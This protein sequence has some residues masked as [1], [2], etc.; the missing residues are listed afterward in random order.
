MST[1]I[2]VNLPVKDLDRT[3]AFFT[4]LG[5]SFDPRF[6]NADATCMIV[7]DGIFVM[8]LVERFF[9]T[10][11]PKPISDAHKSTEVLLCLSRE[12]RAAVED[13]AAKAVAAGG[14]TPNPPKDHGFMYQHGF[15]D[16][17]G[18]L[19]ELVFMEPGAMG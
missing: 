2:F 15:Q 5:F 10:F 12:S 16:L 19:W 3:V 4:H 14:S 1:Q 17:D 8:L 9:Q 13:M 6:T 18:H 7:A 11:T